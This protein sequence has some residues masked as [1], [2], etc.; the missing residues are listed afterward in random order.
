[1]PSDLDRVRR[2]SSKL[3]APALL[4]IEGSVADAIATPK[5]PSG[6]CMKRK[7]Y[8][9][10]LTGPLPGIR[11]AKLVFTMTL[12][13]TAALPRMAGPISRMMCRSPG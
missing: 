9:S 11:E 1:M 13:C 10:Q 6:N 12:I 7:A 3:P 5:S 4:E 8:P 2:N